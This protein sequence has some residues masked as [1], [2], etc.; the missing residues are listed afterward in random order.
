M[1]VRTEATAAKNCTEPTIYTALLIT[2]ILSDNFAS[3][4]LIFLLIQPCLFVL[5]T[6]LCLNQT[7]LP[8]E[9]SISFSSS[10]IKSA[11]SFGKL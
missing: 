10:V 8:D 4:S 11:S 9:S 6:T 5:K 3:Q 7:F 2:L 1:I